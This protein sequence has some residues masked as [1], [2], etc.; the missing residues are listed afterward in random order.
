MIVH[1]RVPVPAVAT[2]LFVV[3]LFIVWTNFPTPSPSDLCP[4][5]EDKVH[6]LLLSSWRSGSSFLGQVFNQHPSVFYLMEPAWHVWTWLRR[7]S[8]RSLRMAVRDL[9]HRVFHCDL[10]VMDSYMPPHYN[11]SHLFMW[12]RS[13][14]L[15]SAPL[16]PLSQG[17]QATWNKDCE[18]RCS[19]ISMNLAGKVC[20]TYSHVVL[21]E[22]R[23][24]EL[25]SLYPLLQDPTLDLRILHLVRDP[26]AVYRSRMKSVNALEYDSSFV[27]ETQK[28]LKPDDQKLVMQEVCR[29][30]I[31][32]HK[33]ATEKAP[34]FLKGRYKL[35]R[36]EDI[37]EDPL[38]A[39][40]DIYD[41]TGLEMT[42]TLEKW[43]YRITHG[44]GMGSAFQITERSATDV[45][46]A[47]RKSL[48][49]TEVQKVQEVC[50]SAMSLLGYRLV[51]S[52]D[53]QK[54]LDL[55]L[56]QDEGLNFSWSSSNRTFNRQP[57]F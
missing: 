24:F 42:E 14:A 51:H 34:A 5:P 18:T 10:G 1:S 16:C 44:K 21:K 45:S 27:L 19:S 17:R 39:I 8:A 50:R 28:S 35:V 36:Y 22:V 23:F 12:S 56:T 6:V 55:D 11:T 46:Q 48:A 20:R 30:H 41:F 57:L 31:R 25:E 26:R 53:E 2:L 29:S 9:M 15:C 40:K 37:V 32:I 38:T 54:L 49:F 3:V 47:W 7:P 13:Q 33:T 4:S 43:I 52:E